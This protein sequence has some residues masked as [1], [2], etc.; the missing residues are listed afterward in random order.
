MTDT[1]YI[2]MSY[3]QLQQI[4]L[5]HLVSGVDEDGPL[6]APSGA[7]S[8]AISGYTEWIS[9]GGLVITIGWDWQ[10]LPENRGFHLKRISSPSSNLMLQNAGGDDLGPQKTAILLETFIDTFNWQSETL[11]YINIRYS[12]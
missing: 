12:N 7:S 3:D 2:R 1:G 11:Q 4:S 5:V 10:M 8:T 6:S 9:Q